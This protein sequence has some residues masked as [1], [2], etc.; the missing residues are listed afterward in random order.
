MWK[1][2]VCM[3]DVNEISD[4]SKTVGNVPSHRL[5]AYY[6][7]TTG[8]VRYAECIGGELYSDIGAGIIPGELVVVI[9]HHMAPQEL[10][11]RIAQ[12]YDLWHSG[13]DDDMLAKQDPANSLYL[14]ELDGMEVSYD[15]DAA[16]WHASPY[17]YSDDSYGADEDE[18][19]VFDDDPL[20][21]EYGRHKK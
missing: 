9:E 2:T 19:E 3:D 18:D 12:T 6:S 5:I 4:A 15:D 1:P 8:R 20:A 17:G 16:A 14:R 21:T 10:A 13:Q 7:P 11:D